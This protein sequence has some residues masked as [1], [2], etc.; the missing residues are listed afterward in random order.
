M[1]VTFLENTFGTIS[2]KKYGT[3]RKQPYGNNNLLV[4]MFA[5]QRTILALPAMRTNAIENWAAAEVLALQAP[6]DRADGF[7]L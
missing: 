5:V 4:A 6:T 7:V 3:Q 2:A 1:L